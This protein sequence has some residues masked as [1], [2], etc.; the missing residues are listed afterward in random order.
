MNR[1]HYANDWLLENKPAIYMPM[2]ET[3]DIVAARYGISREAQDEYALASQQKTARA[4][5]EGL[6]AD[7]IVPMTTMMAVEN[8][9]TKEITQRQVTVDKDEGN[10][11]THDAGSARR[12]E[13]GARRGPVHHGGQCQPAFRRR[14]R[15][16]ADVRHGSGAA[17][18]HA[19]GHLSR[20]RRRRLRARR[21]GHR[22][23]LRRAAPAGAR[24][25]EDGRYRPVGA[26][27]SLR[28]PG[29]L[30]PRPARHSAWTG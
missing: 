1:S 22:P 6:L 7:E 28:Q 21:D 3:A 27:R 2:I 20:L 11:P 23:G 26:E 4:Q 8:K 18:H 10:R 5:Q 29:A 30:L 19:D 25:A 14:Q 9:E 12:A 16:R 24:R 17:R 13:A 15:L